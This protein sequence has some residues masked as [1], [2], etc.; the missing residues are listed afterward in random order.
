MELGG[1]GGSQRGSQSPGCRDSHG[2]PPHLL[3]E[4]A[5]LGHKL[6]SGWDL[7]G[8]WRGDGSRS[9]GIQ[10]RIQSAPNSDSKIIL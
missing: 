4:G 1:R 10:A 2:L 8:R 5:F 9:K 6:R 7:Q 3:W